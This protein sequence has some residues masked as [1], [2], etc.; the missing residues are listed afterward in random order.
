VSQIT[1]AVDTD[2]IVALQE[3]GSLLRELTDLFATE[4]PEQLHKMLEA[5]RR[6]DSNQVAQAAHRLKGTAVTFG[7]AQMQRMCIDIEGR[8]RGGAL[9]GIDHMIAE[10]RA[11]CDRVK[12]AL[13][14]AI[15]DRG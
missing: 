11:E 6:G 2:T 7:A 13:D 12:A 3:D 5:H 9:E 1:S 14:E 10:L 8:A 15:D 4:A